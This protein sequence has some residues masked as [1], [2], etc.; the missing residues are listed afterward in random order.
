MSLSLGQ[1]LLAVWLILLGITWL[2]WVTIS[3]KFLGGFA[4]VTGIVLIVE[5]TV[6]PFVI[7][8]RRSAPPA[9]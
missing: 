3:S 4:A 8:V 1:L 6:H 2:T 7:P 5:A 9:A